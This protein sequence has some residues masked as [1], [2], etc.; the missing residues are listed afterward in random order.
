MGFYE[1]EYYQDDAPRGFTLR[2]GRRMVVTN[3]VIINV[4]IWLADAF[5]TPMTAVAVQDGQLVQTVA[6]R[7]LSHLLAL[8]VS[9][10][11]E[12]WMFWNVLS[13]GFTHASLGTQNGFWHILFNMFMLWMFGRDVEARYGPKEFLTF[14]LSAIVVAGAVWL[15]WSI[16]A[17]QERGSLVG[18]SGGVVAVFLLF[19]LHNP[20]QTLY[21][22]GLIAVPAWLIGLLM[23]GFDLM[24]GLSGQDSNVAW[25]AHLAGAAFAFLYFRFRWNFSRWLPSNWAPNLKKLRPKPRLKIHDPEQHYQNLDNEADRVLDKLH[26]EG[27]ESLNSR[28]RKILEDYSRRMR[29]KR[30]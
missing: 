17:G 3:L 20:R 11:Q 30:R 18:A 8:K 2:S 12:P 5:T 15:G 19:V 21:I 24:R 4:I 23:V 1:R 7:W 14:Y 26:R 27:E 6:G 28:E 13:Y 10:V 25:Q 22:W 29:Q 16:A 9:V